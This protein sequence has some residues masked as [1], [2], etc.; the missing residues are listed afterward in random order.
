MT[1][2]E[3][4]GI[5]ESITPATEYEGDG[6]TVPPIAHVRWDGLVPAPCTHDRWN[7][8]GNPQPIGGT[9]VTLT[10]DRTAPAYPDSQRIALA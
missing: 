2:G 3:G 7:S 1:G 9:N 8:S 4:T 6:V 5:I 10:A